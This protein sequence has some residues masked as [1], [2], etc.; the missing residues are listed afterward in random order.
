ML[1]ADEIQKAI[2]AGD[3]LVRSQKELVTAT[4]L[5]AREVLDPIH[6]L[7]YGNYVTSCGVDW[8]DDRTIETTERRI[9][10]TCVACRDKFTG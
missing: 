6:F 7:P 4:M 1:T 8:R 5:S 2:Q 9:L 10:T 3:A